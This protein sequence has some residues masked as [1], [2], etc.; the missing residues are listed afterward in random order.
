MPKLGFGR[1]RSAGVLDGE[2]GKWSLD[3][4]KPPLWPVMTGGFWFAEL[5]F[6]VSCQPQECDFTRTPAQQS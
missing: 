4:V 3:S 5:G 6:A 2:L 1:R